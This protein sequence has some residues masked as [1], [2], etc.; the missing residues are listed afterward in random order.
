MAAHITKWHKQMCA[1]WWKCAT[2]HLESS[3]NPP[4]PLPQI[5]PVSDQASRSNYQFTGKTGSE[6]H[7]NTMEMHSEKSR[8]KKL[9][10]TNIPVS[11]ANYKGVSERSGE[12][13]EGGGERG[14]L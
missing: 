13:E 6:E 7:V 3:P 2:H 8:C 11:S 14:S 1:S 4:S 5:K 12:E 9:Y 10:S